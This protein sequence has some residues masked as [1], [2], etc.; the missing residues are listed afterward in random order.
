MPVDL[1]AVLDWVPGTAAAELQILA[2]GFVYQEVDRN[3]VQLAAE[4]GGVLVNEASTIDLNVARSGGGVSYETRSFLFTVTDD[5]LM[6]REVGGT[7]VFT[8]SRARG[9]R[10]RLSHSGQES[11]AH[12]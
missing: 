8:L 12:A 4:S 6:L 11:F 10:A 5:T 2:N 9:E 7:L 1:A 3:G